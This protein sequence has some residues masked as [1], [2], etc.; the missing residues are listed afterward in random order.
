MFN[1][2]TIYKAWTYA[3]DG[4][5]KAFKTERAFQQEILCFIPLSLLATLLPFKTGCKWGIISSFLIILIIELLNTAIEKMVDYISKNQHPEA[6]FIKDL[7]AAAVFL[8]FLHSIGWW[9]CACV[10][11]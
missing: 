1:I 7:G 5:L 6:K 11:I 9:I 4:L 10:L 2:K 3:R 8:S